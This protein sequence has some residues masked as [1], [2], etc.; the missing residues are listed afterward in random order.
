[1][2]F[3]ANTRN[4]PQPS[5]DILCDEI[6]IHSS[7]TVRDLGLLVDSCLSFSDH[8]QK[9]HLT[10]NRNFNL[11]RRDAQNCSEQIRLQLYLIFVQSHVDYCPPVCNSCGT[12]LKQSR[13]KLLDTVIR[14]V[15][16]KTNV[17]LKDY[18][19]ENSLLPVEKRATYFTAIWIYK[20]LAGWST[21]S[22]G[23]K[24]L[25]DL[26]QTHSRNLRNSSIRRPPEV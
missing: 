26:A 1:M 13:Q 12:V 19:L 5:A 10:I 17:P 15:K 3:S 7:E 20:R 2:F 4:N 14:G 11:L 22:S 18:K 21:V 9:H 24:D 16:G 23:M 8:I 6:P 25:V